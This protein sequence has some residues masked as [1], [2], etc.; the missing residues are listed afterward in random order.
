MYIKSIEDLNRVVE[1]L[2]TDERWVA[3][4]SEVKQRVLNELHEDIAHDLLEQQAKKWAKPKRGR[5]GRKK[6]EE[7][8]GD[9]DKQ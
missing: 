4:N 1:E 6:Q 8:E 2:S 7:S 9:D 3:V 5:A